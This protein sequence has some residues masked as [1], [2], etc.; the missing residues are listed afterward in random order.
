MPP[1]WV[2]LAKSRQRK[3]LSLFIPN[4]SYLYYKITND[5]QYKKLAKDAYTR[6]KMEDEDILPN[7]TNI[8]K[9]DDGI[10][11]DINIENVKLQTIRITEDYK[12]KLLCLL[13]IILVSDMSLKSIYRLVKIKI[14][15][16][17][18]GQF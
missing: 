9:I 5:D 12:K 11:I 8:E 4:H 16:L 18:I 2:L 13:I 10:N 3:T 6:S 17:Y 1:L 15:I 7:I 14:Q